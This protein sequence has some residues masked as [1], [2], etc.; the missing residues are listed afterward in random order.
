[1]IWLGILLSAVF[2]A[3]I[4][5]FLNVLVLRMPRGEKIGGRSYCVHCKHRLSASDLIPIFSYLFLQG[6]CRYCGKPISPRYMAIEISTA[7]LFALNFYF[8]RYSGN[9]LYFALNLLRW[10]FIAAVLLTVFVIDYEHFLILDKVVLPSSVVLAA[11]NFIL[12]FAAPVRFFHSLFWLG[13]LSAAGVYLLFAAIHYFSRG[14]WM[15]LGDAKFGIL[16]GL[17]VPF[18]LIVL[19][20]FLAFMLGAVL[21]LVLIAAGAKK[22]SSKMP[23]G[24]F[25]AASCIIT[26]YFGPQILIWYLKLIGLY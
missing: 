1:M 16:L 25:L 4:G 20:L 22:M 19:N 6:K 8:L 9:N 24:T 11:L 26:L 7:A 15:G 14:K 2:G 18:P 10:D 21:G 5:S 13:L 17:A 3:I 12:L 23:F